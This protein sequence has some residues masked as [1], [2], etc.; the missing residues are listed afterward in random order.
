M[1]IQ[2]TFTL[3]TL[4]SPP[5][6]RFVLPGVR[7]PGPR[8]DGAPGV[9]VGGVHGAAQRQHHETTHGGPQLLPQQE[10][11]AQ[12]HQVQQHPHE[13]QVSSNIL[14]NILS[15]NILMNILSSN[16]LMNI[17]SSNILMNILSSNIL[18]NILSSN[19]LMNILSSNILMNILSSNILMNILSSNILISE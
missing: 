5:G 12:G 19:I 13:Q 17:L 7:V 16:I 6:Q 11:S 3:L 4:L 14:M 1:M 9:R 10:L 15:S 8:P 18:M 2:G